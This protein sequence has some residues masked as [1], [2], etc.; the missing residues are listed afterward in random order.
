[1]EKS[2][3]IIA[4]LAAVVLMVLV[5]ASF[6]NFPIA[7]SQTPQS[8]TIGSLNH[9]SCALIYVAED[10]GFFKEN[11]LK[12]TLRDYEAG[13]RSIKDL[14]KG[15][16]DI[17][18][19]T[20][21]PIA[22]EAIDKGDIRIIGS[23]D[24]YNTLYLIGRRDRGIGNLSDLKGR[25]VGFVPRTIQEFYLGRFLNLHGM[26]LR[27]IAAVYVPFPQ[28]VDALGNSSV[29]ASVADNKFLYQMKAQLGEKLV[30]WPVQSDQ[31]SFMVMVCRGDWASQKTET[32]VR[33]L[34]SLNQ[35]EEYLVNHPAESK[36]IVQKKLNYSDDFTEAVWPDHQFSLSLDQ[37]LLIAM[38][39]EGR[40]AINNNMTKEKALPYFKDHI[41]TRGLEAVKPDA[42]NIR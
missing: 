39:D 30:T 17:A 27:D 35:A 23:I 36:A 11:G 2:I 3:S 13:T 34:R 4:I 10:Q 26:N 9:E 15:D 16:L 40:W 1:M 28:S 6:F 14:E 25:K 5:G 42:M 18:L 22:L 32:I 21:F 19:S 31:N 29:D 20:E 8:V 7:S 24:K 37:S 41:Y 33:L 12:I 38:N